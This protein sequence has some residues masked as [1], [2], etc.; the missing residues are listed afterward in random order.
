MP[1][2]RHHPAHHWVA[3]GELPYERSPN[4]SPG[5][6]ER[7]RVADVMTPVADVPAVD[8]QMVEGAQVRDLM[9]KFEGS[10]AQHL[11]VVESAFPNGN[12]VRGLVHRVR[13]ER[14]LG[15]RWAAAL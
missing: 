8:W 14:Q 2:G 9:E 5:H 12:R 7:L 3:R 10:G 1:P 4:L 6:G 11:V 13:L 15:V